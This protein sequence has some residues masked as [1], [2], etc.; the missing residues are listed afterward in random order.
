MF[1]KPAIV[2]ILLSM[3]VITAVSCLKSKEISPIPVISYKDFK[4]YKDSADLVLNFTDGDGDIGLSQSDTLAPYDYNCF[5]SYFEKKDE[6]WEEQ[7]L[8]FPFNFRIPVI[9]TS[10]K[11]KVL[12]GELKISLQPFYNN[13][14]SKA[15]S[16]KYHIYIQD[17]ALNKS[18]IVITPSFKK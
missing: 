17:R 6:K 16:I 10:T 14:Y 2:L 7:V 3:T 15:D 12:E 11:S 18:N 5:I 9:N 4:V 8:P 1:R 13:P